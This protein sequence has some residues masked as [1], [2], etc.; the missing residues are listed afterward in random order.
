MFALC[1]PSSSSLSDGGSN[2]FCLRFGRGGS[3]L[4]FDNFSELFSSSSGLGPSNTGV[5]DETET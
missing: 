1:L 3:R 5:I 4:E 2:F